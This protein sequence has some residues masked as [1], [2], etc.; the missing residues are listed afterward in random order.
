M[1]RRKGDD[2]DSSG[3]FYSHLA[4][5]GGAKTAQREAREERHV[6]ASGGDGERQ[7]R[8]HRHAAGKRVIVHK[9]Q[10]YERV[11]NRVWASRR[12][13][14][15][16]RRADA[17]ADEEHERRERHRERRRQ[18]REE[19]RARRGRGGRHYDDDEL[20]QADVYDDDGGDGGLHTARGKHGNNDDGGE[21]SYS[22]SYSGYSGSYSESGSGGAEVAA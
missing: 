22:Y 16:S 13:A 12:A 3:E 19:R 6:R 1:S 21:G 10:D 2:S 17:V 8:V 18:R 15:E 5:Y 20:R 4:A 11:S 14:E 7:A 9:G